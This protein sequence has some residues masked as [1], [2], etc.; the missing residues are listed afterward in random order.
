MA[1]GTG[2]RR[3]I[4]LVHANLPH[5]PRLNVRVSRD[6]GI[7]RTQALTQAIWPL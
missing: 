7:R 3:S 4:G 2:E 5:D 6:R 1:A